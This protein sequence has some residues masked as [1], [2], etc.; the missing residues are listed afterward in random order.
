MIKHDDL[1]IEYIESF[2]SKEYSDTVLLKLL[3]EVPWQN[4]TINMFGKKYLLPRLTAFYGDIGK[5]YN[6]SGISMNPL[7]WTKPLM[8]IKK[9]VEEKA[10][11]SF[12]T[13]FLNRYRSGEDY[14][15]FHSDDEVALG[16]NINI[17]SI[18]LGAERDF[19]MKHKTDSNNNSFS[20]NLK[21][22]SLLTMRHPTQNFWLHSVP[23]RLK[24]KE[25]RIN[26]TFRKI[27]L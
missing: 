20:I 6:Y 18:S 12:N 16:K 23:K 19:K 4:D 10:K 22:G 25:E 27:M 13:V 9:I 24:I 14:Q 21:H 26:L 11:M 17:A 8:D 3:N 1:N 15:G 2:L 5:V 7:P